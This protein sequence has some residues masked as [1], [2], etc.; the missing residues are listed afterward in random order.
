MKLINLEKI[1]ENKYNHLLI[2]EILILLIYHILQSYK[3]EFPV[4]GCLFLIAIIPALHVALPFKVFLPLFNKFTPL[5]N[6]ELRNE[7]FKYAK[8]INFSL[9]NIFIMDGSKRSTKTPRRI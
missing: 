3:I 2:G 8:S 7:I 4:A 6:N 1:F 9:D 5:D